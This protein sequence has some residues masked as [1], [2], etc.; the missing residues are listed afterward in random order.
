MKKSLIS[1]LFMTLWII[2]GCS[3]IKPLF[4]V[5]EL[6]NKSAT[7]IDSALGKPTSVTPITSYPEQMPG[8]YR[9]YTLSDGSTMQVKFYKDKAVTFTVWLKNPTATSRQ[10]LRYFG[11]S[12]EDVMPLPIIRKGPAGRTWSGTVKGVAFKEISSQASATGSNKWDI[13]QAIIVGAP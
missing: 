5:T 1:S 2:S 11:I 4:N 8:E 13:I 6:A 7:V 9:E 3:D 12:M 10:A